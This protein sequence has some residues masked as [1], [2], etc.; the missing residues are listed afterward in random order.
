MV[1]DPTDSTVTQFARTPVVGRPFTISEINHPFPHEYAC[2]GWPILTAYALFHD[3][4]GIMWFTYGRGRLATRPR[5]SRSLR[6]QHRPD[7]AGEPGGCGWMWHRQ[8]VQPAKETVIR[9][10]ND[11]QVLEALRMD[12]NK[13]R[14]FFT[15]GFAHDPAGAQP[16]FRS[17]AARRRLPAACAPGPDRLRH[18]RADLAAAADRKQGS[19]RSR[20]VARKG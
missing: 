15:P 12:R 7:E 9:S 3:W 16:R 4:D 14:P 18:G 19:S 6:L 11:E 2:E 5:A 10:Y 1:N 13:E 8:D 17:T 20:R